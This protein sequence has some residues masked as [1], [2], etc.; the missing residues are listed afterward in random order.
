LLGARAALGLERLIHL[1]LPADIALRRLAGRGFA[2]GR[3][4][5]APEAWSRALERHRSAEQRFPP[6]L[7]ADLVLDATNP[8]GTA[9]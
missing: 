6:R 9:P 7:F 1:E 3:P 2:A 8:L 4:P 5:R